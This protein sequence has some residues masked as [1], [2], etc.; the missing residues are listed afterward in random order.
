MDED[1]TARDRALRGA[2]RRP[3][4]RRRLR[5][6]AW[7]AAGVVVVGVGAAA[8]V[9]YWQLDGNLKSVDIN[10][11]LGTDRPSAATDG[12][13]NILVLGSDSRSGSNHAMAGGVTDGTARSDTAMVVHI[14]RDH[15][16]ASV[17]SIPRDT[18][19]NR[20]A[21]TGTDG[22]SP[23]PAAAGVMFNSAYQTGGAVCAVKT[24]ESMTGLRMNHYVE[25]DFSGFAKLIDDIGGVTVTTTKQ[26]DDPDS[27]LRLPAG[28]HRLNGTQALAFV[29]T[30]HS[31]G[32]GS[33]LG[34]I[35]LQHQ[36]V[37]AIAKQ[38][39]ASSLLSDPGKLYSLAN[40]ATR[41][42]TTDSDLGSVASL[43]SFGESVKGISASK[44]TMVTM[45]TQPA[46]S[47]P[48]RLEAN[49]VLAKQLWG[50][51]K[52]DRP[53]PESVVRNEPAN[54]VTG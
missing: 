48:N 28:T 5:I 9:A 54:P 8:G 39:G 52:Q 43:V 11:Q 41:S 37:A 53:V 10:A 21:C 23:E 2:H 1:R 27:K 31:V 4:Y 25:V 33:D 24:A 44:L 49:P 45:P 16:A 18:L 47:D 32:D 22:H 34:R 50:A 42:V 20:P 3:R 26:I 36:M 30:R 19:V 17:V 51:L 12:S 15:S 29:R 7:S 35:E 14:D 6:A 38:A 40:D 46:V 13:Q